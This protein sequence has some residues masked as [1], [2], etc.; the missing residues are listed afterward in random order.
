MVNAIID[1]VSAHQL[2]HQLFEKVTAYA[3][4]LGNAACR[5]FELDWFWTGDDMGGQK[6]TVP[7]ET[8]LENIFAMYEIAGVNREEIFDR[9]SDIRARQKSE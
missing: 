6:H 4:E 9:A 5:R 8:H 3:I 1:L 2:V 7:P